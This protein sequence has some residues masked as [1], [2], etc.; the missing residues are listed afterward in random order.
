MHPIPPNQPQVRQGPRQP[1]PHHRHMA[2]VGAVIYRIGLRLPIDHSRLDV[3]RSADLQG[4]QLAPAQIQQVGVRPG[5]HAVVIETEILH[6][7]ARQP[8]VIHH[9]RA[10]ILEIG[11]PP[12][13]DA[14]IMHVDPLVGKHLGAVDH[15]IHRDEVAITERLGRRPHDRRRRRLELRDQLADR[16]GAD[17]LRSQHI[18]R[19]TGAVPH[20][21]RQHAPT[22]VA[23]RRHLFAQPHR[24]PG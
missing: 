24:V 12:H 14:G 9:R 7:E 3:L 23:H 22:G 2:E 1:F 17:E 10:E 13:L 19:A 8:A 5:P 20:R 4:D 18:E 21:H 11:D 6:A 15:H 16:H